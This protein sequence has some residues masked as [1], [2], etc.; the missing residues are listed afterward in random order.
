MKRNLVIIFTLLLMASGARGMQSNPGDSQNYWVIET[1]P[2][3]NPYTIIHFYDA[4]NNQFLEVLL[5]DHRLKL[6]KAMIRRLNALSRKPRV[7]SVADIAATLHINPKM[8]SSVKKREGQ[9]IA[10]LK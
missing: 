3:T 4:H 5:K 8:I 1:G 10:G 2:A 7:D 9:D 6:K